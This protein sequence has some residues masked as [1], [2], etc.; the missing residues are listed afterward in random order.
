MN[1]VNLNF[2]ILVRVYLLKSIVLSS[3]GDYTNRVVSQDLSYHDIN[4]L[5]QKEG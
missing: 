1:S 5:K 3:R 4:T 2:R